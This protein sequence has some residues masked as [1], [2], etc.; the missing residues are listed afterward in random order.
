MSRSSDSRNKSFSEA[1]RAI[2]EGN[3]KLL[4]SVLFDLRS[5]DQIPQLVARAL[6]QEDSPCKHEMLEHLLQR[7]VD[8]NC[9][10]LGE[11]KY[12]TPLIK[13]VKWCP[14]CTKIL[15][16]YNADPNHTNSD[17]H[18][19]ILYAIKFSSLAV[20]QML[21]DAGAK[22]R[23]NGPA[24]AIERRR[25][26]I[27]TEFMKRGMVDVRDPRVREKARSALG[28]ACEFK[29]IL[30]TTRPLHH[31]SGMEFAWELNSCIDDEISDV[32]MGDITLE[33]VKQV[34]RVSRRALWF[35]CMIDKWIETE[36]KELMN[37]MSEAGIE[38]TP[39]L[40]KAMNDYLTE[41]KAFIS[42]SRKRRNEMRKNVRLGMSLEA[43]ERWES[44]FEKDLRD[45]TYKFFQD[46]EEKL[47]E[48][49]LTE[50]REKL[51]EMRGIQLIAR[52][53]QTNLQEW[54][55]GLIVEN[56]EVKA[57]LASLQKEMMGCRDQ[58]K[59]IIR[60]VGKHVS[61]RRPTKH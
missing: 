58:R 60:K 27:F 13:A 40:R 20:V 42:N 51:D 23:Q 46:P 47:D 44:H 5:E 28:N 59:Q 18:T 37:A 29:L 45:L 1:Q 55:R 56:D 7:G 33:K 48:D 3:K 31:Y 35:A 12:T 21:L 36:E 38:D 22:A 6:H 24:F 15:L 10:I 17:N 26:D 2:D 57:E 30:G 25:L 4:D 8:P 34:R 54:V 61:P 16:D 32:I 43:V 52:Q 50:M 11:D 41:W 53:R 39:E 19:P 9:H 14:V 49:E